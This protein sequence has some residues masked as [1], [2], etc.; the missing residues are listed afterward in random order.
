MSNLAKIR[1]KLLAA[2]KA[3]GSGRDNALYLFWNMKKNESATVRFTPDGNVNND[4]FW[5]ERQMI[6]IPFSGIKGEM[7]T[8]YTTVQVPCREMWGLDCPILKEIRPWFKEPSLENTAKKY[9]KKVTYLFQGFVVDSPMSEENVPD[10]PIRRFIL[11]KELYGIVKSAILNPKEFRDYSPADY[12]HG[13]D[14]IINK[15]QPGQWPNYSTSTWS[16]HERPL[17]QEERDAISEHG[18]FD[19]NDF[20]PKKPSEAELNAIVEM[21]EASVDG[22]LY[23]PER[24]AEFYKPSN[25]SGETKVNTTPVSTEKAVEDVM[26]AP[27]TVDDEPDA[28]VSSPSK[29]VKNILEQIRRQKEEA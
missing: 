1:E 28:V 14:F 27:E 21:F 17:S 4:F 3:K 7:S 2:E 9:W 12:D 26:N 15:T 23:D 18:L 16:R 25:F 22:E 5:L 8:N 29:D 20:M 10:N 6:K 11:N 19:L 24:W 13:V